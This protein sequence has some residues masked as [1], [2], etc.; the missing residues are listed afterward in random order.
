MDVAAANRKRQTIRRVTKA[1]TNESPVPITTGTNDNSAASGRLQRT[2]TDFKRQPLGNVID[3]REDE[4]SK[5]SDC[6]LFIPSQQDR[7]QT[8]HGRLR[9]FPP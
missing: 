5:I 8:I 4:S 3:E 7:L 9:S 2:L 1:N 6:L